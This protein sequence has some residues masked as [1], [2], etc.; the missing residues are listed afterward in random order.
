[1]SLAQITS[2]THNGIKHTNFKLDYLRRQSK[3]EFESLFKSIR[4]DELFIT[5]FGLSIVFFH[6]MYYG[7]FRKVGTYEYKW[8]LSIMW[9]YVVVILN[10]LRPVNVTHLNPDDDGFMYYL[11]QWYAPNAI[12]NIVNNTSVYNNSYSN[13]SHADYIQNTN[14]GAKI[15]VYGDSLYYSVGVDDVIDLY[16]LQ[17][18]DSLRDEQDYRANI[19][20]GPN[21]FLEK[22]D[23]SQKAPL[24]L[25]TPFD[26]VL[27][28]LD[29]IDSLSR[30]IILN[31]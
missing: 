29:T 1:M 25:S 11:G 20:F 22:P 2:F 16:V 23:S 9:V 13:T 18:L 30:K 5:I 12:T 17:L 10:L 28:K 21:F 31:Q 3:I 8:Y 15:Q 19:V 14:E 27:K 24:V 6:W 4:L 26:S 7:Y